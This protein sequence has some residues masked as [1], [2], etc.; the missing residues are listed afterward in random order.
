[1]ALLAL[2]LP[3]RQ[4]LLRLLLLVW[5][6][7]EL[8]GLAWECWRLLGVLL[9]QQ[10]ISMLLI[11]RPLLAPLVAGCWCCLWAGSIGVGGRLLLLA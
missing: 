11:L 4:V 3:V 6:A 7:L 8:G 2:L 9:G 10:L 5:G 1:V